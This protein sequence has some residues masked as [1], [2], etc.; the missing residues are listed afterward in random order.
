MG[1]WAANATPLPPQCSGPL[2]CTNASVPGPE[3][4]GVLLLF[5]GGSLVF[6]LALILGFAY[7]LTPARGFPR[8]AN[9]RDH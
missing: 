9:S 6:W 2:V 8:N 7:L 1:F 4:V 3:P 5:V